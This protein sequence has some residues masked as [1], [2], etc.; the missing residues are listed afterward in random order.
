VYEFDEWQLTTRRDYGKSVLAGAMGTTKER[1]ELREI[2]ETIPER[3]G[4]IEADFQARLDRLE[5]ELK[6]EFESHARESYW[7]GFRQGGAVVGVVALAIALA[8]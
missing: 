1:D 7:R 2:V 3:L 5:A 6:A 4:E 8:N